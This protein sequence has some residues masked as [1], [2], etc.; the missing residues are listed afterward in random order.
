MFFEKKSGLLSPYKRF[1]FP[2]RSCLQWVSSFEKHSGLLSH[3]LLLKQLLLQQTLFVPR[4]VLSSMGLFFWKKTLVFLVTIFF[5]SNFF[6]SKRFSF[7]GRSCLQWVSSFEKKT[8]VF[9]VTIFFWTNFFLKANSSL[10]TGSCSLKKKSGLL[11]PYKR[12]S[13]PGRSCL[14]WVSSFEKK[15]WSS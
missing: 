5:W 9:L 4:K 12:F 14:Q 1:S 7:P 2:G 3:Y 15:L 8:L 6:S 11:S 10:N 13:F